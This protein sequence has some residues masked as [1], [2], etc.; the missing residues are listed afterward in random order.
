MAFLGQVV[1][2]E[3]ALTAVGN[4][5]PDDSVVC[6]QGVACEIASG[7]IGAKFDDLGDDFVS[8]D[9]RGMSVTTS[10]DGVQIATTN[11]ACQ[12][13]RQDLTLSDG[14]NRNGT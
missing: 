1:L 2:A 14:S 11:G 9:C 3:K 8:K 12:D 10:A 7:C 5:G 6:I 13:S 4:D